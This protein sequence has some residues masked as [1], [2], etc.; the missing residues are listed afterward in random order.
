MRRQRA[1]RG[2]LLLVLTLAFAAAVNWGSPSLASHNEWNVD[3]SCGPGG[4]SYFY[5]SGPSGSWHTHVGAGIDGCHMWME[6]V[7][8]TCN[9]IH[10]ARWYRP[11]NSNYT[12]QYRVETWFE[13]DNHF[14]VDNARY[15][16]Y[17]Y[18]SGGGVSEKYDI[19]QQGNPDK[20]KCITCSSPE[21]PE[22][23]SDFFNG[24]D[25]GY[26][27]LVDHSNDNPDPIGVDW[28]RYEPVH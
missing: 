4:S 23:N 24:P 25:G 27:R 17:A 26:M 21:D 5:P 11:V 19:N 15:K 2:R 12:G 9:S 16:R 22:G 3:D 20:W 7:C 8:P 10:D 28:M 13:G 18:G 6:S 14:Q 1:R